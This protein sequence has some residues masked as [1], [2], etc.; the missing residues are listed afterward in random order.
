MDARNH[1][2]GHAATNFVQVRE[3][4][5]RVLA[6]EEQQREATMKGKEKDKLIKTLQ[7]ELAQWYNRK[8]PRRRMSS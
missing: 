2:Y 8:S 5:D 4:S 1:K 6:L 3:G 7:T